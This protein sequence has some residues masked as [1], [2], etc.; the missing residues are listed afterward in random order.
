[1]M[2]YTRDQV[3][4]AYKKHGS[5]RAVTEET[6][7]PPYTAFI[8]LKKSGDLKSVDSI[9]YGTQASRNGGMAELEFKRLVPKAMAANEHLHANCP[10]FDFDINGWMVDVKFSSINKTGSFRFQTS[11]RK[12]LRPDFYCVFA[13]EKGSINTGYRILLIP[14]EM[15]TN[16]SSV[17]IRNGTTSDDEVWLY[18]VAPKNLAAVFDDSTSTS[19]S[20]K[21]R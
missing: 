12:E 6:G 13:C 19:K 8:W 3:L 17:S 21:A 11:S 7:C 16:S 10:S 20:D 4:D 9:R 14:E 2:A 15:V 18:E 5:I 1:M